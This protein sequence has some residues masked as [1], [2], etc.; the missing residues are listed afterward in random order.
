MSSNGRAHDDLI[1]AALAAGASYSEAAAAARVSRKTVQRRMAD[2]AFRAEVAS[3]RSEVIEAV[4]GQLLG[5]APAAIRTLA[6]VGASGSA[7]PAA[8]V[9]AARA[10]LELALGRRSILD[11]DA[12]PLRD[13]K[14]DVEAVLDLALEHLPEEG[15]RPFVHAVQR[16][17]NRR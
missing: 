13:Y 15:H 5:A 7:P 10:V 11:L 16:L 8:R 4:K 1:V 12:V 14:G 17:T 9:S 3:A 2:A 6:E